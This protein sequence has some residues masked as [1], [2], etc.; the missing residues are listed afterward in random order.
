[1]NT[2]TT[3]IHEHRNAIVDE[4]LS[5]AVMLPNAQTLAPPALWDHVP[6]IL[7]RLADAIDRRDDT[8]TALE[9]LPEQHAALRVRQGYDLRQVIAEYRLLREV[10]MEMYAEGDDQ[11]TE[12]RVNIRALTVLHQGLDRAIAEAADHYALERDHAR[13]KFV[14]ILGHDLRDP[15]N[16]VVFQASAL[17]QRAD[18]LDPHT[19]NAIERMAA[20]GKRMERM[21]RDLLDFARGHLGGGFTI[22]PTTFDAGEFVASR[23]R[24]IADAHPDR[25]VRCVT[26]APKRISMSNGTLTAFRRSSPIWCTTR[27]FTGTIPS[28]SKRATKAS[29]SPFWCGI[30][31]RYRATCCRACS[32]RSPPTDPRRSTP[33]LDWAST[34]S[35]KSRKRTA[36]KSW[37][38]R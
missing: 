7:D 1:V 8:A 17:S 5:R 10:I 29:T 9:T 12:P 4:W 22:V 35:N 13:D 32:M 28:W 2:L 24:E 21:I 3:F 19:V 25:S 15:L 11:L 26:P 31:E 36:A 6:D 18:E 34:S 14:A 33:D 16:T 23:V 30:R 20:S 27:S 37:R 38:S